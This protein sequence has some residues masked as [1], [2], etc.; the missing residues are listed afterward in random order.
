MS[1]LAASIDWFFFG[2]WNDRFDPI[3]PAAEQPRLG[4]TGRFDTRLFHI[5]SIDTDILINGICGTAIGKSLDT[6]PR[7]RLVQVGLP[8]MNS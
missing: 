7:L 5:R 6:P 3:N 8:R 2:G 1:H 4:I